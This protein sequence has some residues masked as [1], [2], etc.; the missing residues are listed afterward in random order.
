MIKQCKCGN[1]PTVY[2]I[3]DPFNDFCT[4]GIEVICENCHRQGAIKLTREESI[5]DWNE[6]EE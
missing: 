4:L 1:E 5:E 6:M 3:K 2:H